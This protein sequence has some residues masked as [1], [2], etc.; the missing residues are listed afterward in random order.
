[1]LLISTAT[2]PSWPLYQVVFVMT[3]IVQ[4][5]HF[6]INGSTLGTLSIII[7]LM[8]TPNMEIRPEHKIKDI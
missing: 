3:I 7:I 1:M 6:P 8:I 2:L 5:L 4:E